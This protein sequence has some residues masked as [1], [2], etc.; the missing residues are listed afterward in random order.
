LQLLGKLV[1]EQATPAV[2]GSVLSA[3]VAAV[4][5]DAQYL[6]C[7]DHINSLLTLLEACLERGKQLF[8][9]KV[10]PTLTPRGDTPPARCPLNIGVFVGVR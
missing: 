6:D 10:L 1:R 5:P 9:S 4:G 3:L 2:E 8:G 7:A